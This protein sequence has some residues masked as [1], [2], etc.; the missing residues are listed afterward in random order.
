MVLLRVTAIEPGKTPTF[1]EAKPALEKKLLKDRASGAI[2]DLHDKIED[3]LASGST[4]TEIA[5]N[6]KLSYQ[7]IDQVDRE[8]RK[9]DGTAVTL[10]AQ[11]D[12]LNAVFATD[13]GVENDPIDAKDEGVVWYEVLG[14]VPSQ[15]KPFDQVKDE[16]VKD[17]HSDEVRTRVSK[18]AQEL[19]TALNGGSK[20]L[21]DVA[22]DLNVEILT[23]DPVKRDG[24]TV[25]VLPATVAQ[26]FTLP[27]KGFGS[28]ASGVEE[29]RIVFQVD[30]VTPPA[31]LDEAEATRLKDQLS[32]LISE[33]AIA[34]YFSA[35]ESRYGVQH[36]PAGSRQADR[37][38]RRAMSSAKASVT[39]LTPQSTGHPIEPDFPSF[40]RRYDDGAP[41]VAWTR[42]VADLETPVSAMLKL[43]HERPEQLSAGIGSKGGYGA[44]PLLNQWL[45]AR[46]S[47]LASGRGKG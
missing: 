19:V 20:T 38:R 32:L 18:Y 21:E 43:A 31:P 16:I 3:Q 15:I 30:K 10:P 34:E 39:P 13:I 14:V 2:F 40:A 5:S 41:Q 46:L 1:E 7:V 36:Q 27:E 44:R 9:P 26:A 8:G 11:A 28:A 12:L 45:R 25:N 37:Q 23:S 22:K 24:I 6:L 33:D 17:W 4:L 42:L 47:H 35:L 29:G